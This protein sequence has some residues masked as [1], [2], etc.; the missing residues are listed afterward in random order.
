[1][2][3]CEGKLK[4]CVLFLKPA[5]LPDDWE[6]TELQRSASVMP[7]VTVRSDEGGIETGY[8]GAVTS[9]HTFLYDTEG[10]LQF[11]GGITASRGHFGDNAGHSAIVSLVT[12]G[13]AESTRTPVFGCSLE[14]PAG[15]P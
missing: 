3:Q 9:G 10:R 6:D 2:A 7:G 5:H 13:R 4:A 8:F 14:D 15:R 1:M 11:S 12:T